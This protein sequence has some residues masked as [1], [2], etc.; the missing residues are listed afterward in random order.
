[1]EKFNSM[2]TAPLDGTL[3]ELD[4]PN[5]GDFGYFDGEW[6]TAYGNGEP[7]GWLPFMGGIFR[8]QN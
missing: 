7:T 2:A 4:C 5:G 3:V 8:R 1:M 6:S